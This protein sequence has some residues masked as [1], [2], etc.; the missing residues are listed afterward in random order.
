MLIIGCDFHPT[1][2]QIAFTDTEN[3]ACIIRRKPSSSTVLWAEARC[4]SA[5]KPP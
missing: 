2:Q 5:W 4:E 1:F 3:D